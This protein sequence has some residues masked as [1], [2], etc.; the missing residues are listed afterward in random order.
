MLATSA[1]WTANAQLPGTLRNDDVSTESVGSLNIE[2]TNYFFILGLLNKPSDDFLAQEI[3]QSVKSAGGDGVQNLTYEA[4][5]GCLDIIISQLTAGC[6]MPRT[7]KVTG[8][9]VKIKTAPLP[10][11]T[12]AFPE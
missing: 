11:K 3:R 4:Q 8:Q 9:I 1:C 6:V 7:Y 2:K 10:G 5:F 12:E